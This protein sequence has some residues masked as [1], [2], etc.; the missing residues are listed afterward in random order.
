M[1]AMVTIVESKND[2]MHCTSHIHLVIKMSNDLFPCLYKALPL[3]R[4]GLKLQYLAIHTHTE[5]KQ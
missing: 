5:L 4:T 1:H 3:I 2:T